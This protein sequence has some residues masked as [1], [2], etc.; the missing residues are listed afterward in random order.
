MEDLVVGGVVCESQIN[1]QA[2]SKSQA[3]SIGKSGQIGAAG[4]T[5]SPCFNL[6]ASAEVYFQYNNNPPFSIPQ[7]SPLLFFPSYQL[8]PAR[9]RPSQDAQDLWCKLPR[10]SKP[11]Q[12]VHTLQPQKTF[13]SLRTPRLFIKASPESRE[14]TLLWQR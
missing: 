10:A 6:K 2:P 9:C 7:L 3:E 5:F 12:P 8:S 14:G 13:E 11:T 1:L 4:P